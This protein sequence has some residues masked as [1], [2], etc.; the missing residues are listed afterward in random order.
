[1]LLDPGPLTLREELMKS[2]AIAS[3]YD[4]AIFT[5]YFGNKLLMSMIFALQ[6]QR[7]FRLVLNSLHHVLAVKSE[8]VIEFQ[9]IEL[10]IKKNSG[11]MK[12]G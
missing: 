12:L 7:S 8:N 10:D 4:Q 9:Y 3:K 5:W 2:E 6:E 1:M 11:N